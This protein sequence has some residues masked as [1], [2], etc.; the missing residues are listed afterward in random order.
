MTCISLWTTFHWYPGDI[1][2]TFTNSHVRQYALGSD[3]VLL[4]I[5]DMYTMV[6]AL[7][8]ANTNKH[9]STQLSIIKIRIVLTVKS[10]ART[11]SKNLELVKIS[12]TNKTSQIISRSFM[13]CWA[14]SSR[15]HE[16][17]MVCCDLFFC[18]TGSGQI[19]R[20]ASHCWCLTD[21]LVCTSFLVHNQFIISYKQ[22]MTIPAF[23]V[24]DSFHRTI[25]L[26]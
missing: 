15:F 2:Y 3:W 13:L 8:K 1:K 4:H 11:P 10:M 19:A 6:E 14:S 26:A 7:C 18:C 24:A 25:I 21:S 20:T 5:S 9:N 16:W 23:E 12:K 17:R 22:T